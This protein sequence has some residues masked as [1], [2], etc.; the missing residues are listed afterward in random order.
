MFYMYILFLFAT[1][2]CTLGKPILSIED[3]GDKLRDM[4][5][6]LHDTCV[7]RSGV[8]E[9]T[10]EEMKTGKFGNDQKAKK[11]VHCIWTSTVISDSGDIDMDMVK[12]ICPPKIK[13]KAPKILQDCYG[14]YSGKAPS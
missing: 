4:V 3:Y 13:N 12:E 2:W 11:Y 10:I 14:K 9:S 7:A 8:E 5:K 6:M 1:N